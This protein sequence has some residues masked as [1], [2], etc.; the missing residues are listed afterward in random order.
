MLCRLTIQNFGSILEAQTLDLDISR[1]VPIDLARQL[2][3]PDGVR[4]PNVA[5]LFG[6]N[7]SGKSTVLRA[8]WFLSDFIL[9]SAS[10]S[11]K[12]HIGI[13]PFA[14][15]DGLRSNTIITI[16]FYS[17][18]LNTE[19][20]ELYRYKIEACPIGTEVRETVLRHVLEERLDWRPKGKW[21]PL[22]ERQGENLIFRGPIKHL[23]RTIPSTALHRR[24]ASALSLLDQFAPDDQFNRLL[25]RSFSMFTNFRH[26]TKDSFTES[27][28][29][30]TF[31]KDPECLESLVRSIRMAD[32]G[33]EDVEIHGS[34]ETKKL[35]FRHRG[36]ALLPLKSESQ[37]TQNFVRLFPVLH[38]ELTFG[39]IALMDELD[40][41][42]HPM[43]LREILR[44]FRDPE[45]NRS[46]AQL[47]M[48]CNNTALMD[49]LAKEEIFFTA[50][51][52]EGKTELYALKD[53]P[54]VRRQANFQREYLAGLY[55][56]IPRIG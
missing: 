6:P 43:L 36:L 12:Q 22:M 25:Q 56:A 41:D 48:A 19:V 44:W 49:E 4:V 42:L 39:G 16:E 40:S 51:S 45:I 15:R 18:C 17:N 23:Q 31:E 34:D 38:A 47:I 33:I 10:R 8:I 5:A 46:G 32:I 37:G 2:Q 52:D 11:P 29:I 24:N 26:W 3:A 14:N 35:A 54:N 7:G 1:K 53:I 30:D 9:N 27:E 55:G 28:L 21:I 13:A 20:N 50:K